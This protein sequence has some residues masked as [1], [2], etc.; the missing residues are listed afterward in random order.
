MEPT[1]GS[2]IWLIKLIRTHASEQRVRLQYLRAAKRLAEEILEH[3]VPRT[4]Y[5]QAI[6]RID[7]L[8]RELLGSSEEKE[9]E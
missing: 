5:V 4:V 7:E 9:V 2:K 8:S 6:D 3:Y 1:P